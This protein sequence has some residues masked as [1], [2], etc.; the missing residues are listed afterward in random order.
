M[1]GR[2][3]RRPGGAARLRALLDSGQTILAPGKIALPRELRRQVEHIAKAPF[4]Q[5]AG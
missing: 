1:T 5:A 4:V 3:T 2:L